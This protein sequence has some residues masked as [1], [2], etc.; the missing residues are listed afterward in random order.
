LGVGN[1]AGT[2]KI[3]AEAGVGSVATCTGVAGV[4]T[5]AFGALAALSFGFG[6]TFFALDTGFTTLRATFFAAFAWTGRVL[7]GAAAV[8]FWRFTGAVGFAFFAGAFFA[9]SSCQRF[10]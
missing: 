3:Y 1:I 7:A 9:L 4:S 2:D 8:A 5:V 10:F 6:D